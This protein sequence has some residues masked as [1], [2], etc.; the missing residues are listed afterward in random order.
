MR[1][2]KSC[3]LKWYLRKTKRIPKF[4]FETKRLGSSA[5]KL[6]V[7]G[8]SSLLSKMLEFD[9]DNSHIIRGM[10]R[11]GVLQ[12]FVAGLLS[13]LDLANE[14]DCTL[15][16]NYIPKLRGVMSQHNTLISNETTHSITGQN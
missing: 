9:N 13:V 6:E 8:R 10:M 1:L 15:I 16:P 11:K 7:L 5:Q 12:Q 2:I 4:E 3:C 14:F